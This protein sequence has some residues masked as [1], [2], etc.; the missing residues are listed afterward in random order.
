MTRRAIVLAEWQMLF[1]HSV[2]KIPVY[3]FTLLCAIIPSFVLAAES[4]EYLCVTKHHVGV[5]EERGVERYRSLSFR[6]TVAS[7][8]PKSPEIIWVHQN[9]NLFMSEVIYEAE[10]IDSAMWES[11]FEDA[12]RSYKLKRFPGEQL[13]NNN[14]WRSGAAVFDGEELE[15]V[16]IEKMVSAAVTIFA[17]CYSM[18]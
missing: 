17:D 11:A 18:E 7:P 6:I 16:L 4:K 15:I 3:L 13:R 14:P 12:T 10:S 5:S 1:G 8:K 9:D 2:M